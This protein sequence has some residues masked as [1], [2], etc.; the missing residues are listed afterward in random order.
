MTRI[1]YDI[2]IMK[3]ISL[4]ESM[5]GTKLKDC[6]VDDKLIFVVQ[7]GQIGRAIGKAGINVKRL[8]ELLKKEIKIV[9]FSGNVI[10]FVANMI[11]PIRVQDIKEEN[12]V[13]SIIGGD[14]KT[15]GMLI[16]RESKNLHFLTDVVKRYFK[17]EQIRIV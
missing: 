15:K 2:T 3:Y 1:R 8:N 16:G 13:I 9:E 12:G 17:I 11:Y 4:F 6:I 5:T 7:E 10:Q 14:T